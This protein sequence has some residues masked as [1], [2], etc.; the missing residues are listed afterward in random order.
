MSSSLQ[1]TLRGPA[2]EYDH[3]TCRRRYWRCYQSTAVMRRPIQRQRLGSS[4]EA[5]TH[6]GVKGSFNIA[7]PTTGIWSA[8]PHGLPLYGRPCCTLPRRRWIDCCAWALVSMQTKRRRSNG[9]TKFEMK[10][11][12]VTAMGGQPDVTGQLIRSS[13]MV[14]DRPRLGRGRQGHPHTPPLRLL[15]AW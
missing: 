12:R 8:L 10:T 15:S 4:S 11:S 5:G 3:I 7:R 14:A 9:E 6:C 2:V 1:A 13:G